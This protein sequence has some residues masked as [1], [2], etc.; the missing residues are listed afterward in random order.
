[1]TVELGNINKGIPMGSYTPG[2]GGGGAAKVTGVDPIA[3]TNGSVAIK[4]DEQTLQVNEQGE[5]SANLDEIGSELSA[6]SGRVTAAEADILAK[7]NKITAVKPLGLREYIKDTLKGFSFTSDGQSVYQ[8]AVGGTAYIDKQSQ[9]MSV[10]PSRTVTDLNDFFQS[11]IDMPFEFGKVYTLGQ[12]KANMSYDDQSAPFILGKTL[13]DGTFIPVLWEAS[14]LQINPSDEITVDGNKIRFTG[15]TGISSL[16]FN[17]GRTGS[18][19]DFGWVQLLDTDEGV[20]FMHSRPSSSFPNNRVRIVVTDA[21]H[22]AR[23]RE[24]NTLRLVPYGGSSWYAWG[25]SS[26][27]AV[28]IGQIGMYSYTGE[29]PLETT[30]AQ[31]GTNEFQIG[32]PV[33]HNYLELNIGSGLAIVDGKLT[34]QAASG[35]NFITEDNFVTFCQNN[36]DAI[37]AAL[38]IVTITESDYAALETKNANTLYLIKGDA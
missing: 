38:G 33:P 10:S 24:C 34:V 20:V 2:E 36:A 1:M 7:E 30:L 35:K 6:L 16:A 37:K 28:S 19:I 22:K 3:V 11:Y 29:A 32:A 25:T 27:K 4:I 9:Y 14:Y 5:L 31:L 23:I 17:N 26:S 8:S 21:G 12:K 13:A 18:G 15:A